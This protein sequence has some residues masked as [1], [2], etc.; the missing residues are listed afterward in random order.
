[1][2]SNTGESGPHTTGHAAD[3]RVDRKKAYLVLKI[4]LEMGFTGIGVA[5]KGNTR[6]LHIDMLPD[7]PVH[8]RPCLWSYP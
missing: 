5:Q 3:L 4:A 2:I 7:A 6:Y 1:M 8:P